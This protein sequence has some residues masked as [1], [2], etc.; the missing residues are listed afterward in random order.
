MS[1]FLAQAKNLR[2]GDCKNVRPGEKRGLVAFFTRR[3]PI[4]LD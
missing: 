4:L 3:S 2:K 1:F